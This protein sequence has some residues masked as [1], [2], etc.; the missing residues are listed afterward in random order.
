MCNY[1]LKIAARNL[2]YERFD[3]VRAAGYNWEWL[4]EIT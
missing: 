1:I 4:L 3:R 2:I